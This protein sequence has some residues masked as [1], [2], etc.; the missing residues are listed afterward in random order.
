MCVIEVECGVGDDD[1]CNDKA[2]Y[3]EMCAWLLNLF[4]T[5]AHTSSL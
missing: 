2:E 3:L 5:T 4:K 1:D